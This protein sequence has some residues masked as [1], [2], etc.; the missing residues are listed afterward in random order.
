[1]L[2]VTN[3]TLQ[4]KDEDDLLL[5]LKCLTHGDN[6]LSEGHPVP[7]SAVYPNENSPANPNT[8]MFEKV[9]LGQG[10]EEQQ[11]RWLQKIR[12]FEFTG[13]YAQ[14]ELGHGLYSKKSQF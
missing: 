7:S 4:S 11:A 2:K 13:T 6:K 1:M 10:S 5:F 14:T 12:T 3:P 9:V 8:G